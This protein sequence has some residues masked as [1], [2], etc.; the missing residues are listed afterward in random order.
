MPAIADIA[1]VALSLILFLAAASDCLRL[2]IPNRI[3]ALV[4]GLFAV[5]AAL[6]PGSVAWVSHLGAAALVL[7]LGYGLMHLKLIG[8]GDV[9]LWSAV[10][11]W[12]GFESLGEQSLLTALLG[13]ALA[14]ALLLARVGTDKL[15]SHATAPTR[16]TSIPRIL[17]SGAPVPYGVA[18][19]AAAVI[20]LVQSPPAF[21][22]PH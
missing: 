19:S 21:L 8:G 16:T 12:T 13:G 4:P 11:L 17:R 3:V 14:M 7:C 20:V 18:I 9:K 6:A 1:L 2:I 22:L 5:T 10:A 15:A